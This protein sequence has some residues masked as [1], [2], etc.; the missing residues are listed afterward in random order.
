[1]GPS[2]TIHV[3]AYKMFLSTLILFPYVE[4]RGGGG[5]GEKK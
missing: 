5:G 4:E 3:Y 2:R 1:M